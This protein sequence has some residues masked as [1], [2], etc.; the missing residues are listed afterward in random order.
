MFTDCGGPKLAL[1]PFAEVEAAIEAA[2]KM[3]IDVCV[4]KDSQLASRSHGGG[5]YVRFCK[6]DK[7]SEQ[8]QINIGREYQLYKKQELILE[9]QKWAREE[10]SNKVHSTASNAT[11]LLLNTQNFS[12]TQGCKG[13]SA[14]KSENRWWIFPRRRVQ[15][16][17]LER[18]Q[19]MSLHARWITWWRRSGN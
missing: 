10:V 18:I 9:R 15:H 8:K 4:A 14:E 1:K 12:E 5:A 16:V 13:R 6:C 19:H 3:R 17:D 7:C 2:K 11:I